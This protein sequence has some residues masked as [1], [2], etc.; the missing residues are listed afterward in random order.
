MGR[1]RRQ[2]HIFFHRAFIPIRLHQLNRTPGPAS[3]GQTVWGAIKGDGRPGW[4]ALRRAVWR[5]LPTWHALQR[6]TDKAFVY[7]SVLVV[8]RPLRKSEHKR[9][10]AVDPSSVSQF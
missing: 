3:T 5:S 1:R 9:D 8:S 6:P 7:P 10:G 2:P 4:I